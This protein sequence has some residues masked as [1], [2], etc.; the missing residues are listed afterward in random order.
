[1]FRRSGKDTAPAAQ[2]EPESVW[3]NDRALRIGRQ[4][5]KLLERAMDRD[6]DSCERH[7]EAWLE[8]LPDLDAVAA[9]A[10]LAALRNHAE[11]GFLFR[12]GGAAELPFITTGG[13]AARGRI[14]RLVQTGDAWW[15]VDYKTRLDWDD[16][17]QK[18]H[19]EA[20]MQAYA[21][22]LRPIAGSL[23]V[24]AVLADI[25]TGAVLPP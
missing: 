4:W 21:A 18:A 1:M 2:A 10:K 6:E 8:D 12:P 17:Q 15:I 13:R 16:P 22:A 14:D 5:H 3:S 19:Y 11:Y 23:A 20:Q 7:W 25:A 24:R 9:R